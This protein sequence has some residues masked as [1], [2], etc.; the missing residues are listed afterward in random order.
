MHGVVLKRLGYH[1]RIL[2]RQPSSTMDDQGAGITAQQEIQE[3]MRSRKL[4][5]LPYSVSS[6]ILQI[7]NPKG[8]VK[9]TFNTTFQMT[10]WN[11]LY[12]RLRAAFD[13]LP[14]S[15][16]PKE[17][18]FEG[19]TKQENGEPKCK[20]EHGKTVTDV[21]AT[22]QKV[23]IY[24]DSQDG[25]P[26]S[27][28]ADLVIAADGPRSMIR[29]LLE[30]RSKPSYAGYVA[31]RGTVAEKDVSEETMRVFDQKTTSFS[32]KG[33]YILMYAD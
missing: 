30:P 28:E 4:E 23:T 10:S 6:P 25:T 16:L 27:V 20:Y 15:Y 13:G 2:E 3:F 21:K 22:A 9:R 29:Q 32:S 8:S 14:S 12:Y 11:V 7:L 24:F 18:L 19:P 1:V 33:S 5:A 17:H 31:W 26:G